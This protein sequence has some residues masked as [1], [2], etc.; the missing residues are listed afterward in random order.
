MNRKNKKILVVC[1]DAGGA[2]VVSAW[3]KKNL[4]RYHVVCLAVGPAQTIFRRKGLGR[5]LLTDVSAAKEMMRGM[6]ID[7]SVITGTGWASDVERKFIGYAKKRGIKTASYL[8]HWVNYRERFGYPGENWQTGLP[9]EVWVGDLHALRLACRLFG[10]MTAVKYVPNAYWPDL[11][12][13]YQAAKRASKRPS[14]SL[15]F[16]DEPIAAKEGFNEFVVLQK[17][18]D[19]LVSKNIKCRVIIRLHPSQPAHKYDTIIKTYR[20]RVRFRK[21][22]KTF[23]QDLIVA[24][25]VI[26]MQSMAMVNAALCGKQTVSFIPN[27]DANCPMPFK[28]IIKINDVSKLK[29]FICQKPEKKS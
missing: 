2:E 4:R 23:V 15:L 6:S 28:E 17:L 21:A 12:R 13:S 10:T 25:L 1:H 5:Y 20:S 3:V 29:K 18:L 26:G 27:A 24:K 9:D 7:D 19:Y 22:A 14:D 11:R 8:D 16:I